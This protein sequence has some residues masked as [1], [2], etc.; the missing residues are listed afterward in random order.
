MTEGRFRGRTR[1]HEPF[2]TGDTG[3]HFILR[4]VGVAN[5]GNKGTIL[6]TS[7]HPI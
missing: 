7:T 2:A 3:R 6:R 5:L 4:Y 1:W